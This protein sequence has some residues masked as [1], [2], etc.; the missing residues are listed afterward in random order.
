MSPLLAGPGCGGRWS[1]AAAVRS[2]PVS[3]CGAFREG[4]P[5]LTAWSRRGGS[6]WRRRRP[7][8]GRRARWPILALR[9]AGGRPLFQADHLRPVASAAAS[10]TGG[11][12]SGFGGVGLDRRGRLHDRLEAAGRSAP[13]GRRSR[14]GRRERHHHASPARLPKL[15]ASRRT[16][17]A[18]QDRRSAPRTGAAAPP[19]FPAGTWRL[20][21]F[22]AARVPAWSVRKVR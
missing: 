6:A 3:A 16:K 19:S 15:Q 2:R 13:R 10:L 5:S 11:D 9:D 1:R 7:P 17:A 21:V 14:S 18:T 8:T 22:R 4:L 20:Q 12:G